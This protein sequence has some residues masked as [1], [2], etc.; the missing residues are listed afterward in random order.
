MVMTG[1]KPE[2]FYAVG[3]AVGWDMTDVGSPTA[4][5]GLAA[6]IWEQ[7]T[8]QGFDPPFTEDAAQSGDED[9]G[10]ER[11]GAIDAHSVGDDAGEDALSASVAGNAAQACLQAGSFEQLPGEVV[12]NLPARNGK[13]VAGDEMESSP[14][15]LDE[16]AAPPPADLDGYDEDMDLPRVPKGP[17]VWRAIRVNAGGEEVAG[18]GDR[19]DVNGQHIGDGRMRAPAEPVAEGTLDPGQPEDTK[20]GALPPLDLDRPLDP[21]VRLKKLAL[22][23]LTRHLEDLRRDGMPF[24][25]ILATVRRSWEVR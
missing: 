11:D 3:R 13:G 2:A 4:T 22:D 10:Q 14:H 18:T 19:A 12:A 16:D 8:S 17:S 24:T 9:A 25:D 15:V 21:A 6:P 5:Q 20:D 7:G 23:G 1:R